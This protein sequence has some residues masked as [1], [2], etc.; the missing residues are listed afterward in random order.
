[1]LHGAMS[2]TCVISV[3]IN[4]CHAISVVVG[5]R[6]KRAV[7]LDASL[8][9]IVELYEGMA[10]AWVFAGFV[11]QRHVVLLPCVPMACADVPAVSE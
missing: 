5:A 4:T 2:Q 8:F 7:L 9:F 6:G 3:T 1:M 10:G 11:H